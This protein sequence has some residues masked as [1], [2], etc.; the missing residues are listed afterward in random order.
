[1]KSKLTLE[2]IASF[3]PH[4]LK[5]NTPAGLR[6]VHGYV[7][8]KIQLRDGEC[9][10]NYCV[11]ILRKMDLTKSITIDGVEK[12]PIRV[13]AEI[14]FPSYN[15]NNKGFAKNN[16]KHFYFSKGSFF[17]KVGTTTR[18]GSPNQLALFQ[19][20]YAHKFDIFGLIEKDL[21]IDADTL[22]VNPYNT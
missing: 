20:L 6:Q 22:D 8:N 15:W 19:W 10:I 7:N 2:H 1:M 13:L 16:T 5:V 11:P 12:I 17:M 14:A 4:G 18:V 3:V 21:A 9:L